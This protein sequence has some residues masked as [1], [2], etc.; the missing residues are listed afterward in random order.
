[1]KIDH[2]TIAGASLTRMQDDFAKLGLTTDYG[3][4]HS[5]GITQMALLGFDDGSYIELISNIE[6][7]QK[8]H[9]FWG[10]HITHNGGPCAWATYSEDVAAEAAH[11]ADLGIAIDGPHYYNRQRPDGA[12]VEWDLAFLD[13]KGAGACL[14]FIIKDITPRELRVRPSASVSGRAGE[15]ALLKGINSVI[16]GVKSLK[17]SSD[18]FRRVYGWS[19]P[20]IKEDVDF[21]ATLAHFEGTAVTLATPLTEQQGLAER[22]IQFNESPYAFLIATANFSAA[23]EQFDL[24]PPVSYFGQQVAWFYPDQLNGTRLGVIDSK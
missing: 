16:L 15:S 12:L 24:M 5:N 6:A 8:H 7:G 1:M 2:V 3:G 21:G 13:D 10:K 4:A 18:L 20:Q 17:T 9:A 22:L 11:V 19:V 14:P 23:C